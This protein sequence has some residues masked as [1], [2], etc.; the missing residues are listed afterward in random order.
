M[1]IPSFQLQFAPH[2]Y[3]IVNVT[4]SGCAR[5]VHHPFT[6][7]SLFLAELITVHLQLN[8]GTGSMGDRM[9]SDKDH[10][11]PDGHEIITGKLL[12]KRS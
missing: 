1:P 8:V 3:I 10:N 9:T 6:A 4:Y 11:S 7:P 12:L 5:D 2:S